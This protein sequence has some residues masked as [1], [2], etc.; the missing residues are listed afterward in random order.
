MPFRTYAPIDTTELKDELPG[1]TWECPRCHTIG[2]FTED[3]KEIM[4]L[5]NHYCGNCVGCNYIH[6]WNLTFSSPQ[7][8]AE[9]FGNGNRQ[10]S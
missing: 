4:S 3:A 5:F 9:V 10:D 2:T 1:E 7:K 6:E 8:R